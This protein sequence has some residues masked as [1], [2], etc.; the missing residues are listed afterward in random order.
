MS[1]IQ[2]VGDALALLKATA[3]AA[4]KIVPSKGPAHVA[5][6][7]ASEVLDALTVLERRVL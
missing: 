3:T 4:E 5:I 7:I 6:R 2:I 1:W